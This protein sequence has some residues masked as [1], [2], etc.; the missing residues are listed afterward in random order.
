MLY[1]RLSI[2]STPASRVYR[3]CDNNTPRR[4]QFD[5]AYRLCRHLANASEA[6]PAQT[7]L[8]F[9]VAGIGV[10]TQFY[11]LPDRGEISALTPQPIKAGTQFTHAGGMQG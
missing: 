11:I 2:F 10:N 8:L 4:R 5:A 6:A 9:W 7:L 3:H 1:T